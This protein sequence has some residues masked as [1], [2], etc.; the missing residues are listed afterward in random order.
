LSKQKFTEK[1]LKMGATE[2]SEFEID[3]GILKEMVF[4]L[5]LAMISV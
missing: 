1:Y 2:S 5:N 3:K 4:Q